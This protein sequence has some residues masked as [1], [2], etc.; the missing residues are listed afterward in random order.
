MDKKSDELKESNLHNI[1]L[2]NNK[3]LQNI[4]FGFC[5]ILVL[6]VAVC[7]LFF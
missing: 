1:L 7:L 3:E 5:V 2:T 4:V 6:L